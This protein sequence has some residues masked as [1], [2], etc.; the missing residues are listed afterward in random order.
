MTFTFTHVYTHTHIHYIV[1]I[2]S[3]VDG[4]LGCFH[5]LVTINNAAMNTGVHAFFWISVFV[6]FSYLCLGGE[7]LG[8]IVVLSFWETSILFSTVAAPIYIPTNRVQ[9]FPFSPSMTTFVTHR[10]FDDSH[11]DSCEGLFH[12]S[13]DLYFPDDKLWRYGWAVA[14]RRGFGCSRPGYGI[15]PFGGGWH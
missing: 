11:S 7:F 1:F 8:H 10:L 2:Y 6:F 12:C 15:S 13:F 9:G 14:C 4:Q 3:F 5:V